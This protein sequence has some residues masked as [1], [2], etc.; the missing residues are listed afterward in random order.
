MPESARASQGAG[1]AAKPSI[2]LDEYIE[3]VLS[4]GIPACRWVRLAC[5]RHRRDLHTGAERG[6]RWDEAA[7]RH[8]IGFFQ[9]LHHS[10]G[11]W[12]G[13]IISLEPWQQF[14]VGSVFGWKR[15]DGTRRFRTAYLEVG[16][17]NGKTTLGA[18]IGLYLMVADGEPGAEVYTAG[19]MRAQARIAHS[20]AT[21]M[22]K[23]SPYLRKRVR[24]VH[25]NLNIPETATKFEPL[26]R[27]ADSMDGLNVHG[28]IVDELHAHKTRETWDALETATGSRR[29]PLM[30]AITTAGYDRQS[31]CYQM[32][33]YVQKVLDGIVEDDSMFGIIYCLDGDQSLHPESK[34]TMQEAMVGPGAGPP[35]M[36]PGSLAPADDWEDEVCWIKA[37]PNLGVSKKLEDM[38]RKA[39]RAKEIPSA[40][41]AFLRLELDIWT[42]AVTKWM[43]TMHW[44]ACGGAVDAAGLRGRTCY[45]GLDLSSIVDVSAFVLVFPPEGAED[46]YQ[47]LCRFWIPEE[48]MH[49]RSHRDRVPYEAWVRQGLMTA[50]S[51]NV[52]DYEFILAQIDEDAQAYDLK[53]VAFDRWG[54]TKVIQDIMEL[55]LVC[56]QFGQ[57]FVSM[58]PPMKE[59]ER[60]VMGHKLAH[61][62]NP[63]LT[64]MAD[65]LVA[66]VDAA[67]N[68]KPDKGRSLE[69][70]D[71]CVA[72]IM[73][74]DRAL[75]HQPAGSVYEGR[76]F[77][78]L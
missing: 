65:N 78:V 56:V 2:R 8:A 34:A 66:G 10:K 70:I 67:G 69:K 25:D 18:G 63:V 24:V 60:L 54:A 46:P 59:L 50:T 19:V 4:G 47:V 39:A 42:Q 38:R 14:V 32:H 71:G 44:R 7:A 53:E 64:W 5:E 36:A 31:L 72:L 45:G 28:A 62:N 76:G 75:R 12:A 40:L 49:E 68:I 52:I 61:G 37:N 21:R 74:L 30:L 1:F 77:L 26:G 48:N 20:E 23:A 15:E 17:K 3:A 58:S 9:F 22:V 57:G 41:N 27:D 11:E 43:N 51:G 55:G 13:R 35:E 16:R 29:Q 33:E 73:G 6:L